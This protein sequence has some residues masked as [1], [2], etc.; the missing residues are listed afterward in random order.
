MVMMVI[1][2]TFGLWLVADSSQGVRHR[3]KTV[4]QQPVI[5][6]TLIAA[7]ILATEST[8]PKW[9]NNTLDL[10]GAFSIPL[11]T[12]ALG[13][14]LAKLKITTWKK[15]LFVS[16]LRVVGGFLI[17]WVICDL[18]N[19]QSVERSVVILQSAM[20]LAVFNYMLAVRFKR[21]AEQVAAMVVVSTLMSFISLPFL[22][23]ILL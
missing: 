7:V 12:I 10:L 15:S 20:P 14:S 4:L 21:D 9:L 2:F 23:W 18:L 11:M 17:A 6:A 3:I 13:V 16:C 22:L 19:L 1:T 8:L 5:Y